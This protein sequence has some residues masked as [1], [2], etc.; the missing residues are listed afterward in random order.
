MLN[1]HP[2]QL[3][4][5]PEFR[6]HLDDDQVIL[7][8]TAEE[9][10]GV[11]LRGSIILTCHE[12]TKVKSITLKF[13]GITNVS[14]SEGSHQ[15]HYRAERKIL[16]KEW[17]FLELK[18]KAHHLC[19][20]QYKWN[21][22]IPLPGN[23]PETVNH[24]MGQVQYR[25]KAYCDR[26]TFSMNYVDKRAIKVT[27]L[28]LPSSL[29]LTQSVII[30]NVWA[31]KVAYD[32]SIPSKVYCSNKSIPISFDLMPIAPHLKIKSVS[33]SLKEYITCSTMDHHKTEGKVINHLRDDRLSLD[34]TTGHWAKIELLHVPSDSSLI[35]YDMCGE[36]IQVKH[37]LKFS[38]AL[39]NLD[40]HIS[41]LRA[42]IPVVIAPMLPEDDD[43]T[44]PA[45]EDAWRSIPYDAETLAHMIA[46]GEVPASAAAAAPP[47]P[48][49]AP[50]STSF[51]PALILT[52]DS[53][54]TLSSLS[55][56]SV[57]SNSFS[58]EDLLTPEP[59]PWMGIDISRVPSYATALRT[60]APC[61]LSPSL[62]NYESI[63]IA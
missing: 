3:T 60:G 52:S 19:Q 58:E 63:T 59:L 47:P 53:H 7:H 23:L 36:L 50:S 39:Q 26:P 4:H 46:M 24:E 18:K 44:L 22:E 10:A 61:T 45:Y 33:C 20:G 48:P 31:N 28:M 35:N 25:L 34:S 30:S 55:S 38:V 15:K 29:E 16:E 27:R 21:F 43:N 11:I 8:G 1:V 2:M 40:G 6:I 5:A 54:S 49:P 51:P 37:K 32:I 41:E 17:T 14:W 56:N 9:S 42:A 62:P 13:M 57:N 12:Q